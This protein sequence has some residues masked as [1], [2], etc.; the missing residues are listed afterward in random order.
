MP[1]KFVACDDG[2]V[3]VQCCLN[4][5]GDGKKCGACPQCEYEIKPGKR[6]KNTSCADSTYCHAHYKKMYGVKLI[7]TQHG[8]GLQA[9]RDIK[10]G[11]LICPLGGRRVKDVANYWVTKMEE[12][13]R[14]EGDAKEVTSPYGYSMYDVFKGVT[15]MV[16]DAPMVEGYVPLDQM[17]KLPAT[18]KW[19]Q[20]KTN[21]EMQGIVDMRRALRLQGRIFLLSSNDY[22]LFLEDALNA[23]YDSLTPKEKS[24]KRDEH[25]ANFQMNAIT[26]ADDEAFAHFFDPRQFPVGLKVKFLEKHGE[27]TLFDAGCLRSVGSYANDGRDTSSAAAME[28]TKDRNNAVLSAVAPYPLEEQKSWLVAEKDIPAGSEILVDYGANYW[29]GEHVKHGLQSVKKSADFPQKNVPN[30]QKGVADV[31]TQDIQCPK[32]RSKR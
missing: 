23:W 4:S 9:T 14:A 16:R 28:A 10:I 24:K 21:E 15:A 18:V 17:G 5:A 3:A 19:R 12:R 6:C 32:F 29:D 31:P 30:R 20:V 7:N 11:N 22:Q 2:S 25:I 1:Q 26:G 8:K 27:T 13:A